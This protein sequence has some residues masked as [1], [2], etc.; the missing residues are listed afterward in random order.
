MSKVDR[1]KQKQNTTTIEVAAF[2]ANTANGVA[3]E[4]AVSDAQK[5]ASDADVI[6]VG[7]QES[8]S[9]ESSSFLQKI[10]ATFSQAGDAVARRFW[11]NTKPGDGVYGMGAVRSGFF[12]TQNTTKVTVE[13]TTRARGYDFKK[14]GPK[15]YNKGGIHHQVTVT[16]GDQKVTYQAGTLHLDSGSFEKRLTDFNAYMLGIENRV[17]NNKDDYAAFEALANEPILINGDFNYRHFVDPSNPNASIAPDDSIYDPMAHIGLYGLTKI[18]AA[19][20]VVTYKGD[21]K[22]GPNQVLHTARKPGSI[23]A[24]GG[25]LDNTVYAGPVQPG[26]RKTFANAN[27]DHAIE[28]TQCSIS[29]VTDPEERFQNT[30]KWVEDLIERLEAQIARYNTLKDSKQDIPKS[31]LSTLKELEK[32]LSTLKEDVANLKNT[33]E[34]KKQLASLAKVA[35]QRRQTLLTFEQQRMQKLDKATKLTQTVAAKTNAIEQKHEKIIVQLKAKLSKKMADIAKYKIL[36]SPAIPR[37]FFESGPEKSKAKVQE[38]T[39]EIAILKQEIRKQIEKRNNELAEYKDNDETKSLVNDA[40][41]ILDQCTVVRQPFTRASSPIEKQRDET[42]P[43]AATIPHRV[44]TEDAISQATGSTSCSDTDSEYDPDHSLQPKPP[45]TLE[46]HKKAHTVP[47][48]ATGHEEQK[49]VDPSDHQLI[50]PTEVKAIEQDGHI[51]PSPKKRPCHTQ[52]SPMLSQDALSFS[53]TLFKLPMLDE[54]ALERQ[55]ALDEQGW[56]LVSTLVNH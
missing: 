37:P 3:H 44:Q 32:S 41:T 55:Q 15:A 36:S 1:D 27:S 4:T 54:A 35:R 10:R 45:P 40:K 50:Q 14:Y 48:Q 7:E 29:N 34:D 16:K 17:M 31:N 51:K 49:G 53:P 6:Q 2:S 26:K 22:N 11:T 9:L 56:Q 25:D 23:E 47:K 24:R 13:G 38:L 21:K 19:T 30:K 18:T 12:S 43:L 52:S 20:P 39:E 8:T 5:F 33:P 46:P 28:A 42:S